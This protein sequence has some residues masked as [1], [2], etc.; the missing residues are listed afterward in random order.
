MKPMPSLPPLSSLP[1]RL[2]PPLGLAL[3][4]SLA[5]ALS[6]AA[7][8]GQAQT[9][10]PA[11]GAAATAAQPPASA[12]SAPPFAVR[13][14]L[15]TQLNQAIDLFR[16]GKTAE[17][18]AIV[19]QALAA[20]ANPQPPETTVMQRLR[21]QLSLQLDQPAEAVKALEAALAVNAQ[22]PQDQLISEEALTRA[23]Y[24]V[25][26][27]AAAA[28]WARKAQAH[29]SKAP[30]MQLILVRAV[31]AQ[32]DYPG[33]IQVLEAQ[34]QR[35]GPL[36]MDELRI[37]ASAYG[38]TKNEAKYLP[39]VER[40]L[41]EHGRTEYWP[42]LLSR[43]QLQPGWQPRWEMDLYRLRLQVDQMDEADD[44]LVLADMLSKAGLPA[45]AQKVVD[46]GFAKGLLGKGGKAAEHQRLRASVTKLAA[47]DRATLA[48]VAAR[49]PAVGDA[50]AATNTFNNGA[51]LVSAGQAERGLELMKAALAG[52]LPDPAQARLQYAQALQAAGKPA[53][54]AEQFKAVAGQP[55]IGLLARLWLAAVSPK[56]V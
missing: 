27:Y 54:A 19:D 22:T 47:D 26:N 43:V 34:A 24:A 2:A 39:L 53:E 56:K 6:S 44:Y 12:A 52:P 8:P 41:V 3:S 45:E 31:F 1:L 5:L 42:D 49:A 51:A 40:L 46:A 35:D 50:R 21:G 38:Q 33:T 14:E 17:A 18:R 48:A 4:L 36:P 29:G 28:D 11:A 10:R 25:K 16:G 30:A 9:A 13:A 15:A 37:L 20:T 7:V 55:A 32:N 23:H